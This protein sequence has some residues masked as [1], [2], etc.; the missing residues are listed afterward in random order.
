MVGFYARFIYRFSQVAEPL[1]WLKRKNVKFVWDEAQQSAF[2]QLKEALATP[3]VLQIPD[4]SR[5]FTLV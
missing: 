3:P 2:L 5:A 1:H 4:F